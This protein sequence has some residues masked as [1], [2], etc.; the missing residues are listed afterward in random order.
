MDFLPI[1]RADMEKR[2]WDAPDFVF[3]SGTLTS[4][5]RRLA[6]R[7][8]AVC[9]SRTGARHHRTAGLARRRKYPYVRTASWVSSIPSYEAAGG[10]PAI[11]EIK[12]SLTSCRGCFGACNFCALTFHQG[13]IV[14]TRSHESLCP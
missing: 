11:Q 7:L 12:F 2:G 10:V 13:R 8:S 1:T 9:W 4:T 5:I 6:R 14:Q 3:V